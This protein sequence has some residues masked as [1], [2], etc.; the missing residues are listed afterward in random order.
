[1]KKIILFFSI[2]IIATTVKSQDLDMFLL[3]KGDASL[4]FQN[5]MNP[6]MKG[7]QYSLNNGWYHTA[8]T[9]KKLGFDIS[10]N[11]NAAIVPNSS[12]TFVF[13]ASNYQYLSLENGSNTMNTIMGG[14]ND[15]TIGIRIPQANDY[16]VAQFTM[17][18]GIG[19]DLP[20][21]AVPSPMVQASVGLLGNTDISVRMMPAVNSKDF[22][23]NLFGF[24]I[25]HNIMQYFG[26]LDKLPLNVSIFG[27]YTSMKAD[28]NLSG[29]SGLAGNNQIAAFDISA[30]TFQALAS[31]DLPI[32]SFYGGIGYERGNSTFKIKGSYELSYTLESNNTTV[33]ETV[34]DPINMKFKT[35]SVRG[36]IGARLNLAFFKLYA[37]YTIKNYNTISTGIAFSFR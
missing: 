3:A 34:V 11:L 10:I 20:L 9:H 14:K 29:N 30:Y 33:T 16:K 12:R 37:D 6:V 25:K 8:K 35:N 27:G 18:D 4:L 15:Q 7:M 1:M 13:N 36:T 5:Y 19:N 32:I 2:F 28:Y 17:P 21:K 22:S 31:L 23:G 24:G 26:P